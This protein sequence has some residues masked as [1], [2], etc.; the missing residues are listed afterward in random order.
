MRPFRLPV[1]ARSGGGVLRLRYN[2]SGSGI[3]WNDDEDALLM[4]EA[5]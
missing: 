2:L 5:A 3:A 1:D 4:L